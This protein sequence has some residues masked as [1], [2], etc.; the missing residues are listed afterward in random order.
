MCDINYTE[1]S[2]Y[3][4]GK[5]FNNNISLMLTLEKYVETGGGTHLFAPGVH[6]PRSITST[7]SLI[8]RQWIFRGGVRAW[9]SLVKLKIN[10]PDASRRALYPSSAIG[11]AS[12]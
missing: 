6:F 11:S 12:C 3:L 5:V 7:A 9:R 10:L 1:K 2:Q 8:P 4:V